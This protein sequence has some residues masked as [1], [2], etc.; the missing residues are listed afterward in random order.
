MRVLF[1]PFDDGY[2]PTPNDRSRVNLGPIKNQFSDQ[3]EA[4]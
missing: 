3:S 2:E 4:S 1:K